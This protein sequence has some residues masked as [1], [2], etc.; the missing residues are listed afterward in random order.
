[1]T[2]SPIINTYRHITTRQIYDKRQRGTSESASPRSAD[3]NL[4]NREMRNLAC[5]SG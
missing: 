2:I 3:L 5:V 1:M 4:L